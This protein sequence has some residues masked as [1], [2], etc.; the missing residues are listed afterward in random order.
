MVPK[1]PKENKLLH[2]LLLIGT[3]NNH[4]AIPNALDTRASV[5]QTN[6]TASCA[7]VIETSAMP[8][9]SIGSV[10]SVSVIIAYTICS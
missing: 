4:F 1:N 8:E 2:G 3:N 7:V 5:K 10:S 6:G 9:I